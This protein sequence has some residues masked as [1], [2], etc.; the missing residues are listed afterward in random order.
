M[1]YISYEHSSCD[2]FYA[3]ISFGQLDSIGC[4]AALFILAGGEFLEILLQPMV[5]IS[6][7]FSLVMF[8]V[9]RQLFHNLRMPN[10]IEYGTTLPEILNKEFSGI[11]QGKAWSLSLSS[12]CVLY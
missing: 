7:R 4:Y 6:I 8:P 3:N 11:N 5:S 10:Y 12:V 1:P 2:G 9:A